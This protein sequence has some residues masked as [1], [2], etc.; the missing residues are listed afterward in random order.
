MSLDF[1][2]TV[3]TNGGVIRQHQALINKATK[4]LSREDKAVLKEQ[5][6]RLYKREVPKRVSTTFLHGNVAW[7]LQA[8]AQGQNPIKLRKKIYKQFQNTLKQKTASPSPGTQLIR[9]WRGHTYIVNKT[10]EGFVYNQQTYKS[11]TPIAKH[12][13]GPKFFGLTKTLHEK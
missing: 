5:F 2:P 8:E 4:D 7:G 1:H 11:L 12:I 10:K 3:W 9:E 13:P 6:V